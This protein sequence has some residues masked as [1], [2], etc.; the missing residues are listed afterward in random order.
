[1]EATMT[2][3]ALSKIRFSKNGWQ[4]ERDSAYRTILEIDYR[5]QEIDVYRLHQ[6]DNGTPIRCYNGHAVQM[7]VAPGTSKDDITEMVEY[8]AEQIVELMNAYDC[9]YHVGARATYSGKG[10]LKRWMEQGL[11][12]ALSGE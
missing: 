4:T 9:C 6:S 2:V 12:W 3:N 11:G 7:T 1:M 8:Y 10:E 5:A